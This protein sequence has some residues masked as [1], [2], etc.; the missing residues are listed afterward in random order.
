[1]KS[2]T[3]LLKRL[4]QEKKPILFI[5]S[6]I[7]WRSGFSH[8]FTIKCK[9]YKLRF[10]P[11]SILAEK[12]VYPDF[13]KEDEIFFTSYLRQGDVV[14]DIG[15][16]VGTLTLTAAN[17]VG[18]SGKVFS[19]EAHPVIFNY[20][21]KN[22]ELNRLENVQL[23]NVAIGNGNGCITFSNKRL[24]DLNEVVASEGIEITLKKLDGLLVDKIENVNLLKVD[25]E[26][27]EKFV[28]QGA[29]EIL[30][31]TE[32]IYFESWEQHFRK[33]DYTTLDI[34]DILKTS[35]FSVYKLEEGKI[36]QIPSN[37]ISE[38]CENLL[39]IRDLQSFR[40]KVG[41]LSTDKL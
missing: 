12:W 33:Y 19:I 18:S 34:L 10:F 31:K 36:I 38:R 15:A 21:E 14:I 22:V 8:I 20:L 5:L 37:Y 16:N 28:F 1:M 9:L 30:R 27:Y 11:T 25:V 39:A 26:G 32:C 35:G 24:D 17:S 6:R 4:K 7:L 13:G 41:F 3:Y 2:V 29:L 40:E 23:F